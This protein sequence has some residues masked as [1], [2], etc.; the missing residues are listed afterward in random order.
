MGRLPTQHYRTRDVSE[1]WGRSPNKAERGAVPQSRSATST[2]KDSTMT[3]HLLETHKLFRTEKLN[4]NLKEQSHTSHRHLCAVMQCMIG[5]GWTDCKWRESSS[6]RKNWCR[7]AKV[8][9]LPLLIC[10]DNTIHSTLNLWCTFFS[11]HIVRDQSIE[12]VH[13]IGQPIAWFQPV[14]LII[15]TVV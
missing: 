2:N 11:A 14:P 3:H 6:V 8:N 7:N 9:E 4:T 1:R 12:H 5:S 10:F 13:Y 15:Q